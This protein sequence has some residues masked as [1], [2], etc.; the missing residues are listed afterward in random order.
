MYNSI[1]I[2]SIFNNRY[3]VTTRHNLRLNGG[4]AFAGINY[5]K[6]E[7][8][9]DRN[10]S[11]DTAYASLGHEI[12]HAILFHSGAKNLLNDTG[13]ETICDA[14]AEGIKH[15]IDYKNFK[16]WFTLQ[17]TMLVKSKG[18]GI[19]KDINLDEYPASVSI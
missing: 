9:L 3:V 19:P 2:V 10:M 14:I 18:S 13:E 15:I 8:R 5:K 6:R 11:V 16:K 17:Q 4:K 1:L 7:I 12:I